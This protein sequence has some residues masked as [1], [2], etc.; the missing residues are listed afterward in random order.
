MSG[1][2]LRASEWVA[3]IEIEEDRG[4]HFAP[5]TRLYVRHAAP[6]FKLTASRGLAA[7]YATEDRAA[8][9]AEMAA[10]PGTPHGAEEIPPKSGGLRSRGETG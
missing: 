1:M 8:A 10:N 7:R 3:W 9:V 6:Y 2:T 4:T 5:V